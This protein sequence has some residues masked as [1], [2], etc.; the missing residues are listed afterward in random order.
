MLTVRKQRI[1][2]TIVDQYVHTSFP[3]SSDSVA[4]KITEVVSSATIRSEMAALE[5][6]GYITRPHSSAGGVPAD[7]GYRAYVESLP[8]VQAPNPNVQALIRHKLQRG[9][10]SVETWGR[11]ASELLSELL[12]TMAVATLPRTAESRWKQLNLVQI[13]DLMTLVIMVIQGSRIEQQLLLLHEPMSQHELTRISN[14]LNRR[15][16]GLSYDEIQYQDM[17]PSSIEGQV[18]DMSLKLLKRDDDHHTPNYYIDGLRHMFNYPELIEGSKAREM[19]HTL[20]DQKVLSSA[21]E[22]VFDT[23]VV[24]VAIGKENKA[25]MLSPFSIIFARY[26]VPGVGTGVVGI[27]GPTRMEYATAISNVVYLA[28]VM[29]EMVET[30]QGQGI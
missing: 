30:V 22:E 21:F 4:Q 26:G 12:R 5:W 15:F 25:D 23:D 6:D 3:V 8:Y 11:I 9:Q 27:I 19:V 14:K 28:S 13:R 2:G 7:K 20:E 29:S 16:S 18:I 17:E 10:M 24:N 1:L